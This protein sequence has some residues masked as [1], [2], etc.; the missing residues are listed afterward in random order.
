METQ[1]PFTD[2]ELDSSLIQS[3]DNMGFKNASPIQEMTIGPI[4][5]GKDIFAQAETGSGKTG[6]FAIPLVQQILKSENPDASI[7][8]IILSPTR[9]L[10]Q[11]T[12]KVFNQIGDTLSIKSICVIG[13]ESFDKQKQQ[14]D[15]KPQV[16][17]A[18]PGRLCD[19][20]KQKLIDLRNCHSV[21][22]DEADR[23]FDMGFQKDIEFVLRKVPN[24][25]QLVMVSA[26]N[27]MDVLKTAYKF[28][29]HP[30]ELKL[31][32]DDLLVDNIDHK[33]A[34][35]SSDEKMPLLVNLLRKMDDSYCLIFCN[36][37]IQTHLVA[38]W[39]VQMGI[40]AKAISGRLAQNKRTRLMEDFRAKKVTTLVCTD[41]AARGLDIKDVNLVVN[42]DLP[43][44][45]ANYVHRIGRTGRAGA[46]GEAISFCAHE[47]CENLDH[48]MKLIDDKIPKMDLKNDDFAT[49]VCPRPYIDAKT[50]KPVDRNEA[51]R[52]NDRGRGKDRDRGRDKDRNRNDKREPRRDEKPLP[53][54]EV[55][56]WAPFVKS[57]N[58][59]G[60][61]R[62]FIVTRE[63][64]ADADQAALGYFR[65][66]EQDLLKSE[67]IKKGMKKFIFFGS[68]KITYKYTLKTL[69][70]KLLTPFLV[71]VVK[72]AKLRLFV[73]VSY[74]ASN[75]KIHFSGT[76]ERALTRN[77]NEMLQ[78]FEQLT[79]V[80]LTSKI[81]M[82][83]NDRLKV[84]CNESGRFEKGLIDLVD[85]LKKQVLKNKKPVLMKPL[86]S[87]ER[88]LVHQHIGKDKRFQSNSK[89]DGRLKKIEISLS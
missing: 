21:I 74:D 71:D 10:A 6:S 58:P 46:K 35:L 61:R 69:Y 48:I 63:S 87:K 49:D 37:Q 84:T 79:K 59:S 43:Q 16:L 56:P 83:G 65:V 55:K 36:T 62:E 85:R 88:R 60:D 42:Y 1:T 13:G 11:Q 9:E 29:S 82:P 78:A 51:R 52:S 3:L 23:L 19:L 75:I 66:Y 54:H 57:E 40:K 24:N 18:T 34:M 67:V 47:D 39:L 2:F 4:L 38:E 77:G 33:I 26:T 31:N 20:I 44:E 28:N 81:F 72:L 17:V 27:N 5:E 15:E 12:N 86:N 70:K 80:Y 45:A 73:K 22:F 68:Q 64:K 32:E 76:D 8:S 25:R 30:I 7:C 89:G 41:V 50:L 14:L 53:K